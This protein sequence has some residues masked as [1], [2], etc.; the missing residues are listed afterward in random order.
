MSV[1]MHAC[2]HACMHVCVCV[3]VCVRVCGGGVKGVC[4]QHRDSGCVLRGV[5]AR[6]EVSEAT[7]DA[8]EPVCRK[9][10]LANAQSVADI[11]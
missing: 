6:V 8:G 7:K 1:G 10:L 3:C 4:T 5:E 11:S 2:M 9:F